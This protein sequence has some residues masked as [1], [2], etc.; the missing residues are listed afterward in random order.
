MIITLS[1]NYV[2]PVTQNHYIGNAEDR[3][4]KYEIRVISKAM[5]FIQSPI[6][7]GRFIHMVPG[8]LRRQTQGYTLN[9]AVCTCKKSCI[10]F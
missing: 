5:F 7:I 1:G 9:Y 4:L 6:K 3:N 10:I 2:A 8:K